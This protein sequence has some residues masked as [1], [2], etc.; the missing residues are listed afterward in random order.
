MKK[1]KKALAYAISMLPGSGLRTACY[2]MFFGYRFG[3]GTQLGWGAV[4]AV[5]QFVAGNGVVI[6]RGNH[7]IGPLKVT[8]GDKAFI[9]RF[10]RIECGDSAA[11]PKM[12]HMNYARE[13]IAG[14]D[15]L[16]H[17]G[18]LFDVYG[19]IRIGKGSWVAGFDSQFL[20]HGAGTMNRDIE[21]GEYCFLGSAVRF[22]PGGGIGNN[23]ILGMGAVVTKQLAQDNVVVGGVPAKVIKQRDA[24]D[25]Y[26]FKKVW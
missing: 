13:F 11:D 14:E 12:A 23:V 1:M 6:R 26:V 7:F 24:E 18:H 8:L 16:I 25:G 3:A 10:N 5:S 15:S 4:I 2:R 21:I 22:S 20:T 17:E 9:G 19:R